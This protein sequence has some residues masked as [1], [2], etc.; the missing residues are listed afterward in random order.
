[1]SYKSMM[2]IFAK[3][4]YRIRQIDVIIA[5]FYEVFDEEIYIIKPTMFEDSTTRICF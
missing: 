3:R 4:G 5:F 2:A 1:M